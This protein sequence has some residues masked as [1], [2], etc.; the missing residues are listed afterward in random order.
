MGK[1]REKLSYSRLISRTTYY[2]KKAL[3]LEKQL[4]FTEEKF[5]SLQ[6]QLKHADRERENKESDY[7]E[8]SDAL[9]ETKEKY[10]DIQE[11]LEAVKKELEKK[12][13]ENK[14]LIKQLQ[15]PKE[16]DKGDEGKPEHYKK[17]I[18]DFEH[19]L[20]GVQKELNEKEQQL[21]VY[22]SRIKSLEKRKAPSVGYPEHSDHDSLSQH[23]KKG[24]RAI[25]YF[26]YS[27]ILD[28]KK[29]CIVR[30]HFHIENVG[31]ESLTNPY[32]CFRFYPL[33]ASTLKGKI[34][35]IEQAEQTH[36]NGSAPQWVYVDDDW[37]EEAKERGEIWL[38][39]YENTQ[40]EANEK[41]SLNDLQIPIKQH[42]DEKV[43]VE[44][45]VYFQNDQYRVKAANQI[46]MT[47]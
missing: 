37:G 31:D 17:R 36:S 10:Q 12:Q 2:Q 9:E 24:K 4:F 38:R 11:N 20:G 22:K 3:E 27:M 39:P 7:E 29:S 41:I 19:L 28:D 25:P 5:Q 15:Q 35:S 44:A 43:I 30:G 47:F 23:T 18:A 16:P 46:L 45:F 40:I 8:L 1:Q 21:E 26:D 32:I 6:K 14:E 13:Q 33:D 42:F 34:I